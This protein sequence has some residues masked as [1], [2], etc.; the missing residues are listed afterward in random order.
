[1]LGRVNSIEDDT[2]REL[3]AHYLLSA[4]DIGDSLRPLLRR[5]A[6]DVH[7]DIFY[8]QR[9]VAPL[10]ARSIAELLYPFIDNAIAAS[11][12]QSFVDDKRRAVLAQLG[13][14]SHPCTVK[15]FTSFQY[16]IQGT[17]SGGPDSPFVNRQHL[18]ADALLQ[19]E[20]YDRGPGIAAAVL[21][22]LATGTIQ[23]RLPSHHL[24]GGRG[25]ANTLLY[26]RSIPNTEYAYNGFWTIKIRCYSVDRAKEIY[27]LSFKGAEEIF[28]EL[29]PWGRET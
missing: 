15:I 14:L 10:S 8:Q 23:T 26:L 11:T 21:N 19:V 7:I 29:H 17:I 28:G 13:V 5:Q 24:A 18:E 20:I 22:D 3:H 27:G 1:M 16:G 12:A 25:I 4:N 6:Q 2:L 9:I